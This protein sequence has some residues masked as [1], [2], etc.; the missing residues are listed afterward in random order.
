MVDYN[1]ARK[2]SP[3]PLRHAPIK[4]P[5]PEQVRAVVGAAEKSEP[6]LAA[7]L[8]TAAL[9]GA[10]RGELCALRSGPISTGAHAP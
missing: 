5:T 8:L 3:P 6:A 1:V 2:A 9:T 7:L 4:A 10:R